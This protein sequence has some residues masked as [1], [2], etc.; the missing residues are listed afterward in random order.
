MDFGAL[1][2]YALATALQW[3]AIVAALN[4]LQVVNTT[5]AASTVVPVWAPKVVVFSFFAFMS[6]RSRVF[7]VL[8]N[9]RPTIHNDGKRINVMDERKRP[10]WMPP[11]LTFPIVWT[12]IALLRTVSSVMVWETLGRNLVV[13]PLAILMLHLSIG[14]TWNTINNIERRLGTAVIGVG[15]VWMSVVGVVYAYWKTAPL[16]GFVLAPSAVW[17]TVASFLVYS[18]WDLN[19]REPMMPMKVK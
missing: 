11:P 7:S 3:G 6:L 4:V 18:I 16:A 19:G 17:I 10:S 2:K 8:N 13:A 12:T 14:D 5:L 9:S 1:V 15:F